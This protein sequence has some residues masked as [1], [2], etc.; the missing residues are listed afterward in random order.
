MHGLQDHINDVMNERELLDKSSI[1]F[2]LR[3]TMNPFKH[4]SRRTYDTLIFYKL[5]AGS[6]SSLELHLA[7]VM[8]ICA[9]L[10]YHS[11]DIK[12]TSFR[13]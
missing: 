12:S 7:H 10:I 2:A 13:Q 5:L 1:V 9:S 8:L 3:L 6:K 11:Q 4:P